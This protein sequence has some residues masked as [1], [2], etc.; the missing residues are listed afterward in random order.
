MQIVSKSVK[1]FMALV[2]L[3][4]TLYATST[5][6]TESPNFFEQV[7]DVP[8]GE[9]NIR[10][11]YPFTSVTLFTKDGSAVPDIAYINDAGQ[12][13]TWTREVDHGSEYHDH[14][15]SLLQPILFADARNVMTIKSD[16]SME[17]V[18]HFYG[19]AMGDAYA[20]VGELDSIDAANFDREAGIETAEEEAFTNTSEN[21]DFVFDNTG[22][23]DAAP[24]F[25]T[26]EE[27]SEGRIKK[28]VRDSESKRKVYRA[29]WFYKDESRK[30]EPEF[31]PVLYSSTYPDGSR[32]QWPIFHDVIKH[33]IT[34]HHTASAFKDGVIPEISERNHVY[35]LY[36]YHTF[37]KGWKDIGYN[38]IVGKTGNIYEG[39]E[40]GS[41]TV[42]AHVNK[43]NVGNIG[44][45]LIGNLHIDPPTEPQIKSAS[46]LIAYLALKHDIEPNE[47][48]LFG[49]KE[50][51]GVSGHREVADARHGTACPGENVMKI[52]PEWR[53]QLAELKKLMEDDGSFPMAQEFLTRTTEAQ[54]FLKKRKVVDA[55]SRLPVQLGA[56]IT[57][58]QIEK[59]QTGVM[60]IVLK[61]NTEEFLWKKGVEMTIKNSPSWLRM[62]NFKAREDI[63][64]GETGRF[65][66]SYTVGGDAPN[67]NYTLE[68]YPKFMEGHKAFHR[69]NSVI[70]LPITVAGD[71]RSLDRGSEDFLTML[72]PETKNEVDE[73]T[74][75]L[76]AATYE[77]YVSEE[78]ILE[79]NQPKQPIVRIHISQ[80]TGARAVVVADTDVRIIAPAK[81]VITVPTGEQMEIVA[82]NNGGAGEVIIRAMGEEVLARNAEIKGAW[83]TELVVTNYNRGLS[84]NIPYNQFL[85]TLKFYP[86]NGG[87]ELLMVNELGV[88]QY[89]YGVSEEPSTQPPQK[90]H[91]IWVATRGYILAY[92]E[93]AGWKDKFPGESRYDMKD[94]PS[95]CVFYLGDQW[96]DYNSSQIELVDQTYGITPMYNGKPAILPYFSSSDGRTRTNWK[97]EYPYIK[98]LVLPYDYGQEL[99]GHGNGLSAYTAKKL[100]EIDGYDYEQIID[101]FFDDI[102]LKKLY[103]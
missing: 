31:R 32:R 70:A 39:R 46:I 101:Y 38:Y 40:G 12:W 33:L 22:I 86:E 74:K 27:W 54:K 21:L 2:A 10:T 43:N 35:A 60:N 45:S 66:A 68:L 91:A 17:L 61:N 36:Q 100:A 75:N 83:D 59:N 3:G 57:T 44:V 26:R 69:R 51:Y 63:G 78:E 56:L 93:S 48:V 95:C 77:D 50:L 67:G 8:A 34:V 85:N 9:S 11:Q 1:I 64:P 99:R 16:E 6:N 29:D 97:S 41:Y 98:D 80:F 19:P 15:I 90:K 52:L 58:K 5:A 53:V 18:A 23:Q 81:E 14:Y 4:G 28:L 62:T 92:S 94:L 65:S 24:T 72:E 13:T 79:N 103:E 73:A 42:G 89:L 37:T 82:E 30:F 102:D 96:T 84:N 87:R 76:L 55:E 88:E 71:A 20:E 25:V 49:Q 7:I 47:I